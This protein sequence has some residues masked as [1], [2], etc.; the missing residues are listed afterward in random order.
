MPLFVESYR[1][2]PIFATDDGTFFTKHSGKADTIEQ[3]RKQVDAKLREVD[4][5]NAVIKGGRLFHEGK[6]ALD[7]HDEAVS[8][9]SLRAFER[10]EDSNNVEEDA[11][12]L[13]CLQRGFERAYNV[14]HGFIDA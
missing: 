10:N 5:E 12:I 13:A 6:T 2:V 8:Y 3:M 7:L 4:L 14:K 11:E 9:A 1:H